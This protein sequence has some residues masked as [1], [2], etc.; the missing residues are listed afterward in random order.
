MEYAIE[1]LEA[2]I[3]RLDKS[4]RQLDLMKKCMKEASA[5]FKEINQLR[6]AIKVLKAKHSAKT[7]RLAASHS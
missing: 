5:R 3:S 2:E 6:R 1:I 4:I 7:M